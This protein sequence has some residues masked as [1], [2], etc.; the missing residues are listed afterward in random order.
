MNLA[1]FLVELG[2]PWIQNVV[3]KGVNGAVMLMHSVLRGIAPVQGLQLE[4]VL[5]RILLPLDFAYS[6]V[7]SPNTLTEV[8]SLGNSTRF[9]RSISLVDH[10]TIC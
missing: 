3:G 7:R 2:K 1:S 9:Y 4:V 5:L 8:A 6:F 10:R